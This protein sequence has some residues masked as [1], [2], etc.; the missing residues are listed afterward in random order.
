MGGLENFSYKERLN[1]DFSFYDNCVDE[2][3][4][5]GQT[6]QTGKISYLVDFSCSLI[7]KDDVQ[8]NKDIINSEISDSKIYENKNT[9]V[10][11]NNANSFQLLKKS[12]TYQEISDCSERCVVSNFEV[13][14]RLEEYCKQFNT[15]LNHYSLETGDRGYDGRFDDIMIANFSCEE[16]IDEVK[17]AAVSNQVLSNK[18]TD[19]IVQEKKKI[20]RDNSEIISNVENK[21]E[22]PSHC[23]DLYGCAPVKY[24]HEIEAENRYVE[25][26]LK[27]RERNKWTK[28]LGVESPCGSLDNVSNKF[29]KTSRLNSHN[30]S[31]YSNSRLNSSSSGKFANLNPEQ[32]AYCHDK[33]KRGKIKLE[34]STNLY[35]E[36]ESLPLQGTQKK[37]VCNNDG[38]QGL[39]MFN[40]FT[41]AIAGNQ[42]A[43]QNYNQSTTPNQPFSLGS[44][45]MKQ[46]IFK[47]TQAQG[48]FLEALDEEEHAIAVRQYSMS[49]NQ[50]TAIGED[51]ME[52]ILEKSH[53]WQTIINKKMKEG[54]VLDA[55]AKQTFS[56]GIPHYA[57]GTALCIAGG[58]NVASQVSTVTNSSGAAAVIGGIGLAF[59]AYDSVKA[60]NLFFS[61]TSDIHAFGKTNNVENIEELEKAKDSLGT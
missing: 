22:L 41:G 5:N 14:R 59:S 57:S 58:F 10:K 15:S 33:L 61:S 40:A 24:D 34:S 38:S 20:D 37:Y 31:R 8:K 49:L 13:S 25:Q 23:S 44:P 36:M 43:N 52:K 4:I 2:I 11:N 3:S 50:G 30:N 53:E 18:N 51:D 47:L 46:A 17:W 21:S 7:A 16:T 60:L 48:F 28:N 27:C 9:K 42:N 32:R 55:K 29:K 54:F 12:F 6:Q 39:A 19:E 26:T 1:G 56:K 35:Y 45:T